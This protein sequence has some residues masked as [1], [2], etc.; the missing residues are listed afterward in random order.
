[1]YN[2]AQEPIPCYTFQPQRVCS[3]HQHL[4]PISTSACYRRTEFFPGIPHCLDAENLKELDLSLRYSVTKEVD[5]KG[6]ILSL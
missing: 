1:M 5:Q 3:G 4:T 2:Q 6:C